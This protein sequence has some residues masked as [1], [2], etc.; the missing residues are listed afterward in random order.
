MLKILI[1]FSSSFLLSLLAYYK[2]AITNSGIILAFIC[3]FII[4]YYGGIPCFIILTIVFLGTV[5]SGKIKQDK[6]KKLEEGIIEKTGAKDIYQIIANVSVG[7]IFV[8]IHG[9]NHNA[10][11]L[12]IYASCMAASLGD[13]L[14]SNIGILS[15]KEPINI[16]TWKK[17][18]PG[19]SGNVSLLGVISSLIGTT[20]IGLIY[21]LFIEH[22]LISLLIIMFI[23]LLGTI[24]D[25]ILGTMQVKYECKICHEIT[26]KKEHC[27][28]KT[29]RKKGLSWLNND[30]VNL[31]SNLLT[32]IITY[33]LLF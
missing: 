28:E 31:I 6:R 20:L 12:I 21:Y 23:G 27:K 26:E 4:T 25:S 22:N 19:I 17:S 24:I 32:A 3:S 10:K 18:K 1:A 7:T 14:A 2:K 13:T 16:I 5:I 8:L 15:K 30:L 9:I 11:N 29:K 33:F